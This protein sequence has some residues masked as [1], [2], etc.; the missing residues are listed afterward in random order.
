MNPI[1]SIAAL[2][3]GNRKPWL[4]RKAWRERRIVSHGVRGCVLALAVPFFGLITL[5]ALIG[6]L[7][8]VSENPGE[9]AQALL[10]AVIFGGALAAFTYWW[11]VWT[12]FGKSVCHLET[13]PGVIGGWFK[14]SVEVKLPADVIPSV[15]V[16]LENFKI[17][18]R[19]KVT[20][21]KT[22]DRVLP[23][24]FTRIQGDKYM[25]PI[26]FQI[27][28]GKDYFKYW[29]LQVKAELPGVDLR[30]DFHV[31]IFETDEA[32]LEEQAP[33]YTG[34][35]KNAKRTSGLTE[36][37]F[38]NGQP[39]AE[40]APGNLQNYTP[41]NDP[42]N[43]GFITEV[44]EEELSS[45][46]GKNAENYIQKFRKFNVDGVDKFSWTWHWPAFFFGFWWLLYRKFYVW[47]FISLILGII[48]YWFFLNS[49]I[50]GV[51]ANFM[52][53]KKA[54]KRI[55]KYKNA[56]QSVDPW[57]MAPALSKIG[58]VT[59]GFVL[60]FVILGWVG[61]LFAIYYP[62]SSHYRAKSY[63][64][65]AQAELGHAAVAQEEYFADHEKYAESIEL[66]VTPEYRLSVDERVVIKILKADNS[67]YLMSAYHKGGNKRFFMNSSDGEIH[68]MDRYD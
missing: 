44:T 37:T 50:Y 62:C 57:Q 60:L 10:V 1:Q 31:P 9:A 59:K 67:F 16:N 18:N 6:A 27:P 36:F 41:L 48:P 15:N 35:Q 47:A 42:L 28:A 7:V 17:V 65:A 58:G 19:S 34:N 68:E 39:H 2:F 43:K 52:Y 26:R 13:L 33:Y 11:R 32:P 61:I 23:D 12:K 38:F 21:W 14:A 5:M 63:N 4:A 24:R 64:A 30:A 53:Y 3:G 20:R 51:I 46:I 55:L 8:N 40:E 49:F 22:S 45:F 25:V 56:Q 66:L 29:L 54:K